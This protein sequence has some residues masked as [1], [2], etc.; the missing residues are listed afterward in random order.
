MQWDAI[1]VGGGHNGLTAAAYLGIAG[2]RVLV[3]ERLGETGGAAVSERPFKGVDVRISSYAY[4]VSLLPKE[5]IAELDLPLELRS[6]EVSSYT[7]TIRDGRATGLLVMRHE[8]SSE[9]SFRSLSGDANAWREWQ[10]FTADLGEIARRL[11]P[12]LLGSLPSR[13]E[14]QRLFSDIPHVW[15]SFAEQPLGRWIER[16]FSDD[17]MRGVVLTDG[18]IGTFASANEAS[19]QQN[20]CFLYHVVGDGTGDWKVPV[21]GMGAISAALTTAATKA[22]AEVLTSAEVLAIRPGPD[23]AE[24]TWRTETGEQSASA[25]FVLANVA[26]AVLARLLGEQSPEPAPEGAQLKVNMVVRRLPRMKSGRNPR[27]AFAGTLHIDEGYRELEIAFR[28]ASGGQLP[29][30]PP[31]ELYCHTL[32]D[33]SIMSAELQQQGYQTLTLFGLHAPARLFADDPTA[34]TA[35]LLERTLAGFEAHLDEPL[36]DVIALDQDG[37]PC[38]E[39]KCPQ[40]LENALGLPGGN[41]FHRNL[42][43]PWAEDQSETGRW[44]VDTHHDRVL[45]CG[46]GAR[47]GG[48]VSCIAG[49]SAAM[50]LLG[51]R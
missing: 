17:L 49:R 20:R 19:L 46:S 44:G 47:R 42:Q 40:D 21:G 23:A 1:I 37:R 45:L 16:A 26:P 30:R 4:L 13:A 22:G 25:P 8:A 7:P 27:Q 3:L 10:A 39:A 38:I 48:A 32:S 51:R 9:R 2:R 36:M 12:T 31:S 43:W 14:A 18:L 28:E 29:T 5:I 11:A 24:V 6:R 15:E 33:P 35:E 50:Q 41:I 34:R